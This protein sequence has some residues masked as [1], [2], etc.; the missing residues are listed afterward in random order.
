MNL[1][2]NNV[3]Q[4]HIVVSGKV[5]GVGFRYYTQMRAAQYGVT[6]WVKNMEDGSVEIIAVGQPEDLQLFIESVREGNPFSKVNNMEIH[7]REKTDPYPSFKI[8][9]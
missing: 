1:G 9:Y 4:L 3:D 5:Q 2:V 6:G 8:K 7:T